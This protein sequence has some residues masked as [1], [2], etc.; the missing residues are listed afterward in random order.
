MYRIQHLVQD[1]DYFAIQIDTCSCFNSE[2]IVVNSGAH[3]GSLLKVPGE[4][5]KFD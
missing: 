3:V 1:R 5:A 4:E 2:T